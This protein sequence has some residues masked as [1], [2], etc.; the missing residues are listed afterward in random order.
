MCGRCI[1]GKGSMPAWIKGVGGGIEEGEEWY[2]IGSAAQEDG[3]GR[4]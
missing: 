3:R 4:R 1:E 2:E